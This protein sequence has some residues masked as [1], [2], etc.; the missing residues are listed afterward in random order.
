VVLDWDPLADAHIHAVSPTSM[1]EDVLKTSRG[2]DLPESMMAAARDD[3]ALGC[4]ALE[5]LCG[6]G[7]AL[8]KPGESKVPLEQ[9]LQEAWLRVLGPPPSDSIF[10]LSLPMELD[11][12]PVPPPPRTVAQF[13][14]AVYELHGRRPPRTLPPGWEIPHALLGWCERAHVCRF[15]SA[16]MQTT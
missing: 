10:A 15:V 11:T 13:A 12:G 2:L 8:A 16:R 6:D 1:P 7:W 9:R 5:L 14:Q 3:W 4:L